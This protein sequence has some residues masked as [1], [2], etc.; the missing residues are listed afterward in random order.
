MNHGEV[1]G[2]YRILDRLGEGGMGVVYRGEDTRLRRQVALKFLPPGVLDDGAVQ[3]FRREALAASALNHPHIC[4]IYDVGD[5]DGSPFIVLEYLEGE[6]LADRIRRGPLPIDTAIDLVTQIADALA[7]AHAGGIVHRDVK[8]G[9][10]FL[11]KRGD[12]KVLDFGLA[13]HEDAFVAD[14]AETVAATRHVTQV[15][16]TLGTVAYMSPEQARAEAVDARSDVFSLGVVLY[17]ALTGQLPFRGTSPAVIFSEILGGTPIP[18]SQIVKPIPA[19][20]DRIVARALEKDRELRYQT[21]ADLRADLKR[22]RHGSTAS[23]VTPAPIV[24]AARPRSRQWAYALLA[25]GALAA[26]SFAAWTVLRHPVP[27]DSAPRALAMTQITNTGN[28][29]AATPSPDGKYVVYAEQRQDQHLLFMHQIATGSTVE[30]AKPTPKAYRGLTVAPDG[31]YVYAVRQSDGSARISSLFRIPALGGEPRLLIDDVGTSVAFSP[32]GKRLAFLRRT[33]A[34]TAVVTAAVDGSDVRVV[35]TRPTSESWQP[36]ITWGPDGSLLAG[37]TAKGIVIVPV[38]GGEPTVVA[39]PGWKY[40]ESLFWTPDDAFI[41]TAEPE[42][43]EDVSRHQLLRVSRRGDSIQLLTHDLNDYHQASFSRGGTTLTAMQLSATARLFISEGGDLNRFRPIG[44]GNGDGIQ[45]VSFL[46]DGRLLFADY[47]ANGWMMDLDGKG[48]KPLPLDRRAMLS[49]RTCVPGSSVVFE[50]LGSPPRGGVFI[51]DVATGAERRIVDA[52]GESAHPIC[53]ADGRFVIYSANGI[54]KIPV[55]GGPASLLAPQGHQAELSPDGNL[56][57]VHILGSDHENLTLVSASTGQVVREL[58]PEAPRA[59]RWAA[60]SK[61]I[62]ATLTEGGVG[63]LWDIPIDG[64]PRRQLTQFTEDL[65]IAFD[66]NRDGRY[67][68]SRGKGLR[69]AVL[70]VGEPSG[71]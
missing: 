16:T 29:E 26:G 36:V 60:S 39:V 52:T 57:A 59:F 34:G 46:G 31:D 56:F 30:I 24:A 15:G 50:R 47:V 65:I 4:T 55:D 54:R 37:L 14:N 44:S 8:P 28:V 51:A 5:H 64:S 45:G 38:T 17:E 3:R 41:L 61:S 33:S 27:R 43:G 49:L 10:V 62:V 22:L 66:I 25:I 1:V 68:L 7:C 70:M 67:V 42:E 63:N 6:T 71:R 40:L 23:T 48:L 53:T 2:H 9:N 21:A 69:D 58:M 18:P 20:L 32:D 13:K 19:E 11:T 35:A 12:A